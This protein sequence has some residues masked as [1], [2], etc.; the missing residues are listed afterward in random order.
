MIVYTRGMTAVRHEPHYLCN[1]YLRVHL[2]TRNQEQTKDWRP[3]LA[4]RARSYKE[5][6]PQN[7]HSL[8]FVL[9]KRLCLNSA[10]RN[11]RKDQVTSAPSAENKY[12][13][14]KWRKDHENDVTD[15]RR[16]KTQC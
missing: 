6:I 4:E 9:I 5:V 8:N 1:R 13:R 14:Q 11:E 12:L 15:L 7:K 2:F 16:K 3:T 10:N